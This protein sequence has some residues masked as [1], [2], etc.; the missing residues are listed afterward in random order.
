MLKR[1]VSYIWKK[2]TSQNRNCYTQNEFEEYMRIEGV[3]YGDI[4]PPKEKKPK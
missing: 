2:V 3:R 1:I 4:F